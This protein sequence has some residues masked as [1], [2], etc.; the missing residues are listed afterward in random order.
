MTRGARYLGAREI[1]VVDTE[2]REPGDGEVAI[3]VAF[4]GICGTDLHIL[5]GDMDSRVET[6]AVIGH[7]MSG[8]VAAAGAGVDGWSPGDHVTV[9]PLTWCGECAACRAGYT[10]V[11]SRLVFIG[12]DAP[13]SMQSRWIVPASTLVAL[14]ADLPLEHGALMEPAAVAVHDVRRGGVMPRERALIIGGGPVGVLVACVARE[15]GAEVLLAELDPHR[16]ALAES[17]G[18]TTVDARSDVGAAVLDWTDGAGAQ[19]VFEVSGSQP[20]IDVAVEVAA[21]RGRVVIVGIHP[22][23]RAVSL[24]RVFWREL[25]LIGARVYERPDFERAADLLARNVIPAAQLITRVEPLDR[26]REAFEAL[27]SGGGVMKV[28]IDCRTTP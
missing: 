22:Q 7:E 14:P 1:D 9:M 21:V 15:V 6:P 3:D 8:I 28:L 16:R 26:A 19:V 12:I 11:C 25:T 13:G 24:H 23:P 17:L 2:P 5:H 4:T 27:E 18:F 10:H 20:G